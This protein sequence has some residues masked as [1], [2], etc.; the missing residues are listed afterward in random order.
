MSMRPWGEH[1]AAEGF[2]VRCPLLPGHGTSWQDCNGSTHEQ[3][4]AEVE[5]ALDELTATCDRVF[6]AGP[7]MGRPAAPPPGPGRP[8]RHRRRLLGKPALLTHRLGAKLLPPDV[9]PN[10]PSS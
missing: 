1:L 9:P 7:S 4:T 3:W 8:Y 2:T 5:R 10:R 6:V